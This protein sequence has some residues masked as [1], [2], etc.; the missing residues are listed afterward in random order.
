VWAVEVGR[1]R[2]H[3][4]T[5][6]WGCSAAEGDDAAAAQQ[7]QQKCTHGDIKDFQTGALQPNYF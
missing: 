5:P 3:E 2:G 4:A 6:G 7:H 1:G